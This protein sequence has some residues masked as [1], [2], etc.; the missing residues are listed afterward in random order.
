LLL[1]TSPPNAERERKPPEAGKADDEEGVEGEEA[2]EGDDGHQAGA[3]DCEPLKGIKDDGDAEATRGGGVEACSPIIK[4]E[5]EE[6]AAVAVAV[7]GDNH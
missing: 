2:N 1:P 5:E 3:A 4:E 6:V 7:A